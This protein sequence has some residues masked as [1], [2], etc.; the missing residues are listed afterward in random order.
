MNCEIVQVG[1]HI[2][3]LIPFNSVETISVAFA[4]PVGSAH[5]SDEE[6]GI[7]HFI[8]HVAF[9]GTKNFSE[10]DLKYS[11]EVVGGTLNAFTTRD[12]TVYYAKVPYTSYQIT[13]DVLT[14]LVFNP[15]FDEKAV[16]LEKSVII[17]EI[18]SY[19]EDHVSRVEDLF[20]EAV[21]QKPYSKPISGYE[22]TVSSFSSQDLK[23]FHERNYGNLRVLVVGK[24]TKDLKKYL[25]NKLQC[26]DKIVKE[27]KPPL[28]FKKPKKVFEEKNDLT[29]LH[30]VHGTVLDFGVEDEKFRV[31]RVLETTLGS[32][33]S[34][35]LFKRIR[36]DLGLVY[37]IELL[38]SAWP[39][40]TL[41]SIYASTS[42][43][44][45][46]KYVEEMNKLT[47]EDIGK[48]FF[49]YGKRRL[50]GKLQMLTESVSSLFSYALGYIMV[51][52]KPKPIEDVIK[53]TSRVTYKQVLE[54]W[55][56]ICSK[57][58]YWA[59]VVPKGYKPF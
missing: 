48:D 3:Y 26:Y 16:E 12:F 47:R 54:L 13:I 21:L 59:F 30:F 5:E 17:E 29:Q 32:G 35:L 45:F 25:L 7:S 27:E 40:K 50:L 51:G 8:E 9:K 24:I 49:E 41:F 34:C 1:P 31:F 39:N 6:A 14:D 33:M 10:F 4:V 15:I 58:W 23:N 2:V 36:E 38:S 18:K 43:E 11:V 55:K 28:R 53:E 42:K 37:S 19:N 57:D 56:E 44:K 52:L 22:K 20:I 46:Q